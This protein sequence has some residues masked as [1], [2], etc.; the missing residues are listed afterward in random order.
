MRLFVASYFFVVGLRQWPT[1]LVGHLLGVGVSYLT[2]ITIR[3]SPKPPSEKDLL[4]VCLGRSKGG[5]C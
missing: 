5:H 3:G 1:K 2:G 4:L